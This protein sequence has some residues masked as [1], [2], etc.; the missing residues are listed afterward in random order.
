MHFRLFS[1]PLYIAAGKRRLNQALFRVADAA[2]GGYLSESRQRM[3]IIESA[4]VELRDANRH[5]H[6]EEQRAILAE[7][8]TRTGN[9]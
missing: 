4:V 5:D 3:E 2:T 7:F 1:Y 9:T 6:D 8:N